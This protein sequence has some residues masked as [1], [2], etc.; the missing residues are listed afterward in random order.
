[1]NEQNLNP[2]LT[3]FVATAKT[4]SDNADEAAELYAK[5]DVQ[6]A[7]NVVNVMHYKTGELEDLRLSLVRRFEEQ[8]ITPRLSFDD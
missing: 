4:V 2:Y 7:C 1:M 6:G 5:G 3:E 8:G